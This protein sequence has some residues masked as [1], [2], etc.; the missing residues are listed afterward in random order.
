MTTQLSPRQLTD[1]PGPDWR[2]HPDGSPGQLLADCLLAAV[3]A[4]SKHNSQPWRFALHPGGIDVYADRTRR[5]PLTDPQDRELVI[6][7]GAAVLNLRV[8]VLAHGR[9]PL[10]T[11]LPDPGRPDLL[12]RLTLGPRTAGDDTVRLLH[13]AI[14]R[15]RS[16]R[17]P[18]REV[19]VPGQ[20]VDELAAAARA[21]GAILTVPPPAGRDRLLAIVE[22]GDRRCRAEPDYW[23]ELDRWT[24]AWPGRRDG[25]PVAAFGPWPA[26]RS[27]PVRDF[28]LLQPTP[29]R[30]V[31]QFEPE[32][33]V[34]V[35]RTCG[36][37]PRDWLRA[38]QALQRVLLTATV[39]GLAS[40]L[41]TQPLE[42]PTLRTQ[43]DGPAGQAA[44]AI[45]R[46]G[47]GPP[48][49]AAP[50]RPLAEV[51]IPPAL[52][53]SVA[54]PRWAGHDGS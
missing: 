20:V 29:R 7:V 14:P 13:R 37:R 18:F 21:E 5:L 42:T 27:V 45:I 1:G 16:N 6:S 9:L 19:P 44:Q 28:G 12:A 34:A 50:R 11:L 26:V 31:R 17:R 33:T 3:A 10:L 41:L 52:P 48:S 24:R 53:G 51:L 2:V 43:L 23:L 49:A 40:T 4:P 38:G 30:G 47:Y 36:D 25:V 54:D 8:A 15:R 39:R 22:R 32:P 46:L 35:L